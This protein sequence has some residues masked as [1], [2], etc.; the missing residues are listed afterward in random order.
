MTFPSN[1]IPYR[2]DL[3]HAAPDEE[4]TIHAL[5]VVFANMAKKV[6]DAEGHAHRA[7]HAKGHALVRGKLTILDGLPPQLAQGL[8]AQAG[9]H[10]VLL[11]WSSPPA[12]QLPDGVSTP[13]A[14]AMKVLDVPGE[15]LDAA[16]QGNSQDFLMVNGPAF[17]APDPQAFL[18]NVKLLAAT[19]NRTE[20]G[21]KVISAVLRGA[22]AALEAVGGESG[23][24]K[25]MGGE[26]QHHPLG[27]TYFS[28]TPY[29]YGQHMAKFSLAPVAPALQALD[30]SA[31]EGGDDAQRE[32]I[33]AHFAAGGGEW[34]LRVQ[35]NVD[36]DK[37]PIED[38]SVAW[39]Q[40]LSPYVA[41]ARVTLAPQTSWDAGSQRLEDETAFDQWNCLAAH[42]PLGAV[43]RARRQVMAVSRDFRSEFNRCPI[44][45]PA[46]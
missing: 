41:V 45:E 33:R 10:D 2:P 39:P 1:P 43:N 34:E 17:N 16:K 28:Q 8:F 22:E 23:S 21:K 15:R 9:T 3:E 11:R 31:I 26:P 19:T 27:E 6:A 24:L 40:D 12:E 20:T 5:Q 7:V 13:R 29:L 4:E 44:H 36:T 42:R 25:A 37:M 32:A 46:A 38:A 14:V 30:G 18:K 35:L